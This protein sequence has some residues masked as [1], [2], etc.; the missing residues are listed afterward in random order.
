M[1]ESSGFQ[2]EWPVFSKWSKLCLEV[3]LKSPQRRLPQVRQ[4]QSWSFSVQF[5]Q[6]RGS[7]G[8]HSYQQTGQVFSFQDWRQWEWNWWPQNTPIY[9]WFSGLIFSRQIGH[10]SVRHSCCL[11]WVT[12]NL[13]IKSE[14]IVWLSKSK[15][16]TNSTFISVW[17]RKLIF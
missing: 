12:K 16:W 8:V 5:S 7:F 2:K 14:F 11:I 10:W 6:K 1:F 4:S 13:S 17:S 3:G 15:F 9:C